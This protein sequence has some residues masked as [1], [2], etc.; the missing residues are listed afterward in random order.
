[1]GNK[2][3]PNINNKKPKLDNKWKE[4]LGRTDPNRHSHVI[5]FE[6]L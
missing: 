2:N 3:D 4:I 5:A 6:Q 1:M